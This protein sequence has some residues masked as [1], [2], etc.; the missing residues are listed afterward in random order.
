MMGVTDGTAQWGAAAAAADLRACA[1]LCC[2]V[3]PID[4]L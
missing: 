3:T 1:A 2:A 4:P